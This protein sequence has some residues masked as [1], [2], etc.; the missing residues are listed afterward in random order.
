[1]FS[2]KTLINLLALLNVLAFTSGSM[3]QEA[4][5]P[6]VSRPNYNL[7]QIKALAS[8]HN[9]TLVQAIQLIAGEEGKA[10][11]AGLWPNP[12]LAYV[13]EQIGINDTAGEFQGGLIR[14]RIVTGGKLRLSRDK[15]KARAKVAKH[16]LTAQEFR[17]LNDVELSFYELLGANATVELHEDLLNIAKD[18][19]QTTVELVNIGKKSQA[20]LKMAGVDLQKARLDL[21]MA[22]NEQKKRFTSLEAVVG[23]SL[24]LNPILEG[25]LETGTEGAL[26]DWEFLLAKTL[27]E[28]PQV[29]AALDKLR[30]DEI[31]LKREQR[32]PIPD[33]VLEA[34]MGR[35]IVDRQTVYM[36]G[37]SLEI[38]LFDRNQGTIKQAEADLARQVAEVERVKLELTRHFAQEY[39]HY[40]TRYRNVLDYKTV[41]L[42]KSKAAFE[43]Q[44]NMYKASRINWSDVLMTQS[45]YMANRIDWIDHLVNFQRHRISLEG[46]LLSNGLQVPDSPTPPSHIDSVPKPR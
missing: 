14:Q 43:M 41:V 3:A 42:P 34:G 22:Q 21:F 38:P 39:S 1:M 4:S 6:V 16:N 7:T 8:Q 13:G 46:F 37:V 26:P 28:S 30:A 9:P 11:Q 25:E 35:N 45:D 12:T 20:D 32:E 36:A 44:L 24:G 23:T 31:S 29:L 40:L 17:V 10:L 15:Y 33:L 27:E 18:H 19:Y 2:R 5:T